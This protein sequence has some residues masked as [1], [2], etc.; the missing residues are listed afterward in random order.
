MFGDVGYLREF[1]ANWR[2]LTAAIVGMAFGYTFTIYLTNIVSP[3]LIDAFGW[4]KSE[5]ALLGLAVLVFVFW[6]PIAGRITDIVGV[7]RMVLTSIFAV[8]L[9]YTACS[10]MTGTFIQFYL[11]YI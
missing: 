5:F 11:L 1:R 8:P 6:S 3:Y 7:R 2:A 4:S 10:L 9:S